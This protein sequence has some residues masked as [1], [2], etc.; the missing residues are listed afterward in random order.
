MTRSMSCPS[1]RLGHF[2]VCLVGLLSVG[3]CMAALRAARFEQG[4]APDLREIDKQIAE[5]EKAV[6]ANLDKD[7][8][9]KA[10]TTKYPLVLL[11]SRT[12]TGGWHGKSAFSFN[13]ETADPEKHAND[14]QLSF[15]NGRADRLDVNIVNGQRN[16]IVDLGAVDFEKDVDPRKIDITANDTWLTG[17]ATSVQGH[18]YLERIQDAR[19]NNFFVLF[20]V[21]GL[22]AGCK[23][24]AFTWRRL[25]GGKVVPRNRPG[26]VV[27]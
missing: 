12:L 18:V 23:Y 13:C 19:G 24:M 14:V 9:L 7:Q 26:D 27:Q 6:R 16:L 20:K 10:L 2:V 5:W 11:H 3:A 1:A 17:N 4:Q 8:A 15:G 25:P 22:D 21:L